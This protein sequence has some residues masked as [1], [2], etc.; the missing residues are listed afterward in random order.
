MSYHAVVM[1]VFSRSSVLTL[2]SYSA[3]GVVL[4]TKK[5]D[6]MGVGEGTKGVVWGMNGII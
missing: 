1:R 4:V 2:W 5:A 6:F 3:W